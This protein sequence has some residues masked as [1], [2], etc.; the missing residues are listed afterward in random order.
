[1]KLN[2]VE[3]IKQVVAENGGVNKFARLLNVNHALVSNW[4]SGRQKVSFSKACLIEISTNHEV[5]V[6]DLLP[7][8]K[9][10]ITARKKK[11]TA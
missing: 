1:M 4:I 9:I 5:L 6:E 3:K 11:L 8:F 2:P 10:V 7:E